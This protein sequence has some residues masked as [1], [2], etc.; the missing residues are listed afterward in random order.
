L[1][2]YDSLPLADIIHTT[3]KFSNNVMAQQI[4]LSLPLFASSQKKNRPSHGSFAASQRWMQNWWQQ[5]L[6]A[7]PAPQL[8]NGSGLSRR[9]RISAASLD[10]LLEVAARSPQFADFYDS[11]AIA[12][13][14]GTV[15]KMQN[16]LP[17]SPVLGHARLKTGTLDDAKA[18]AG[19]VTGQ[20]GQLYSVVGII[21]HE[22]A[23][24]G[25]PALDALLDW[26]ARDLPQQTAAVLSQ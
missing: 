7:S 6:P 19:Y 11:L 12:G 9:E 26:V 17:D 20:S 18:I 25:Q 15:A 3:N 14:D 1:L 5:H 21:N 10:Q 4:F 2:R 24:A 16:R 8:E 23:A 22:R 13:V